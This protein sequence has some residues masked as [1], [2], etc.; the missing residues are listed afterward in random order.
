MRPILMRPFL[1]RPFL[2][3]HLPRLPLFVPLLALLAPAQAGA[4]LEPQ[5]KAAYLFKFLS[6]VD[7]PDQAFPRPDAPMVIG[8]LGAD[9]VRGS[10]QE[11]VRGRAAQGHPIEVRSL[12]PGE[13]AEGLHVLF[14]GR[15]ASGELPKVAGLPGVLLVSE[16][17]GALDQG[18]MVN[19]V[20]AGEHV[21]FEVA[22]KAAESRG[23]HI[24]SRMLTVAQ[25]VKPGRS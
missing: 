22:P 12:Q 19:L 5:V 20:H 8:V 13:S 6:Y 23:L 17:E 3:R 11:I 10:L 2:T 4:P 18:A 14:V 9:D 25:Y 7:W 1:T 24:S 21:R 16:F 15:S